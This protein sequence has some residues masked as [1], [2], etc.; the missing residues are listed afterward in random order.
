MGGGG[1]GQKEGFVEDP[2][3]KAGSG[4]ISA[5]RN[6][7]QGHQAGVIALRKGTEAGKPR[8]N[9][10]KVSD[11]SEWAQS[12]VGSSGGQ[13]SIAENVLSQDNFLSVMGRTVAL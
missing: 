8:E 12:S 10:Q 11:Q 3:W 7:K 13:G 9:L 5:G 2:G 4:S 6:W 1:A